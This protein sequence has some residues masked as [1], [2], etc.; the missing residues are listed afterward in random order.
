MYLSFSK[1]VV[2][3]ACIGKWSFELALVMSLVNT[4]K[5]NIGPKIE[6]CGTPLD[7]IWNGENF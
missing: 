3:L 5:K 4:Y 2:K 7:R 6:F 1:S